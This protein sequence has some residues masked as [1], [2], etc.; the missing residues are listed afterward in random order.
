MSRHLEVARTLYEHLQYP[1]EDDAELSG[2]LIHMMGQVMVQGEVDLSIYHSQ[3]AA[4][5][6]T[7]MLKS[8]FDPSD[9]VWD[10]VIF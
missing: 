1:C 8:T 7:Q 10:Y 6:M 2:C 9:P 4:R 3:S 5:R